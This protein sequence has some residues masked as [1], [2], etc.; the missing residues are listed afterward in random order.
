MVYLLQQINTASGTSYL[1]NVIFFHSYQ[2]R[3]SEV[4]YIHM[5]WTTIHIL[6]RLKAMLSLCHNIVQMNHP[7]HL[8]ITQNITMAHY[9]D[10]IMLFRPDE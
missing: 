5:R 2:E 4:V 8:Y 10:N 9:I 6:S 3:G 1:T 7:H